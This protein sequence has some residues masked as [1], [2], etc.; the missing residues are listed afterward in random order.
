[1]GPPGAAGPPGARGADGASGILAYSNDGGFT[2]LTQ[3]TN[4]EPTTVQVTFTL[5][6]STTLLVEF[7]G[8]LHAERRGAPADTS[9]G[10]AVTLQVGVDGQ[11][12]SLRYAN[13][14]IN[15]TGGNFA[16]GETMVVGSDT[17]V[18]GAGQHTLLLYAFASSTDCFYNFPWLKVTKL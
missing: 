3:T 8:L 15:D 10:A 18:L 5:P 4:F 7:G 14:Q 1:M 13:F 2:H 11:P 17:T 6:A 9:G 12:P 16:L